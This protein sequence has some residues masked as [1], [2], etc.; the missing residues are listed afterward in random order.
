MSTPITQHAPIVLALDSSTDLLGVGLLRG[1]D[2]L[3][4]HVQKLPRPTSE[5]LLPL[6]VA[7]LEAAGLTKSDLSLVAVATG[8]G[9]F[10]GIRG[11]IAAAEG[12]ALGLGI[13]IVGISTLEAMA[14]QWTHG[15]RAVCAMLNAGRGEVYYALY[16][17]D[18]DETPAIGDPIAVVRGLPRGAVLCGTFPV[19]SSSAL[20]DAATAAGLI[21]A[22]A[23]AV[24]GRI[25]AIAR[26]G[27]DRDNSR[28]G[29]A[30]RPLYLRRPGITAPRATRKPVERSGE[31]DTCVKTMGRATL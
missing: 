15:D 1:D 24:G 18:L 21:M 2:L 5:G 29:E 7:A 12:V 6:T 11:G 23:Y 27:L 4:A 3:Y 19:D 8:P 16:G 17:Q 9:S 22:P 20:K 10:N 14:H 30:P 13:P 25:G 28:P 31:R 26:L